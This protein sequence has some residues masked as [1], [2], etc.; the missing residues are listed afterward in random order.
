M[1]YRYAILPITNS[2]K[3]T[4]IDADLFSTLS[5]HRWH[6]P[7]GRYAGNPRPFTTIRNNGKARQIRLARVITNA[8][9]DLYP[10]H[11]NGN[12]LDCRRENIELVENKDK[13][14]PEQVF[15]GEYL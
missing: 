4:L 13:A 15:D 2:D 12:P 1:K 5:I 9:K 6:I 3:K 14:G 8:A 10:K 7:K 11:L